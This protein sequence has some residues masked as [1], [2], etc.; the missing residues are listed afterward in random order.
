MSNEITEF[1]GVYDA[2]A[3]LLGEISYWIGARLGKRHCSLCDITHGLFTERRDWKECRE[4]LSVAFVTF[5]RNDA[6]VDVLAV[7]NGEFPCVVARTTDQLSVV[8]GPREL[9]SLGGSPD[10]LVRRLNATFA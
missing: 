2:D 7:A 6:P 1:I 5:H 10:A 4:S 3:T 9:E 8:L